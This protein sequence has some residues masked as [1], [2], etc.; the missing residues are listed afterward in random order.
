MKEWQELKTLLAAQKALKPTDMYASLLAAKP[1][2]LTNVLV[3]VELMIALSPTTATC[4]RSFSA[5]NRLKTDLKT[6]MQ[7][8]T[9]TNLLRVKGTTTTMKE[10]DPDPA[11]DHSLLNTKTRRH[12][13]SI[14]TP[15]PSTSH[16][17]E[18][19]QTGHVR[20]PHQEFPPLPH[21]EDQ[22]DE[23]SASD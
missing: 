21:V 19:G 10:F 20:Q 11:I 16:I 7:Q 6:R 15:S 8:E 1:G 13:L 2:D 23:E 12:I 18:G 9:L 5:M 14:G 4:E 22:S 3:L 17:K